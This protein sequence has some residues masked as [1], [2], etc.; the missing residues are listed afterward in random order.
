MFKS[1]KY[2]RAILGPRSPDYVAIF[3]KKLGKTFY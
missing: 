3:E 2:Q 1:Q